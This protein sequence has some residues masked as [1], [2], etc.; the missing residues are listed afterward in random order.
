MNIQKVDLR[1]IRRVVQQIIDRCHPQRIVLFGSHAYGRTHRNSDVDLLV[2]MQSKKRPAE[3]ASDVIRSLHFYPFP[4][5]ILVR[6][7]REIRRRLQVGDPFF[8]EIENKGKI[9]YEH[10]AQP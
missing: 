1:L 4:M 9:L 8:E 2:V 7:P 10:H 6:T 3:R 5:D